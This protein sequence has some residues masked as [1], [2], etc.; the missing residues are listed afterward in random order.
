MEKIRELAL[1]LPCRRKSCLAKSGEPCKTWLGKWLHRVRYKDAHRVLAI[2]S[3][4][5]EW[6]RLY[7]PNR[8]ESVKHD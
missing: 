6:N 2:Y 3:R 5:E 4:L 1:T 7:G 8:R